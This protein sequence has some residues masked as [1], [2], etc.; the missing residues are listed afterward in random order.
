MESGT[1]LF[2]PRQRQP[3]VNYPTCGTACALDVGE[4]LAERDEIGLDSPAAGS[5]LKEVLVRDDMSPAGSPRLGLARGGGSYSIQAQRRQ[6]PLRAL[7]DARRLQV[8]LG[9]EP[10]M[11]SV[12]VQPQEARLVEHVVE[13]LQIPSPGIRRSPAGSA[14]LSRSSSGS[15]PFSEELQVLDILLPPEFLEDR[16]VVVERYH[17][18][19]DA[20]V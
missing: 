18:D 3:G 7:K 9:A 17:G 5:P 11:D 8:A 16:P 4:V 19:P 14:F 10:R 6:L 1:R 12:L 2:L 13:E 15:S 20:L